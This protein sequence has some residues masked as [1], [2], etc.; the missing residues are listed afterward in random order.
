[1]SARGRKSEEKRVAFYSS[2]LRSPFVPKPQ[3]LGHVNG[4]TRLLV[5]RSRY[6]SIL[7]TSLK[8]KK[9]GIGKVVL[10]QEL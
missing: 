10:E 3:A 9:P 7:L 8:L 1:M 6:R 4:E 2:V 5:S